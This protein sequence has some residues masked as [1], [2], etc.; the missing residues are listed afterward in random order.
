MTVGLVLNNRDYGVALADSMVTIGDYRKG[1][2]A[3]K[4][5]HINANRFYGAMVGAGDALNI[6]A[7]FEDTKEREFTTPKKMLES[8][9]NFALEYHLNID[10][11]AIESQIKIEEIAKKYKGKMP[12]VDEEQ[13][14]ETESEEEDMFGFRKRKKSILGGLEDY[15]TSDFVAAIYDKREKRIRKYAV[16]A[17]FVA[18]DPFFESVIGSGSDS[19]GLELMRLMSG[20]PL[21]KL[22]K[23]E[24]AFFG[25]CAYVRATQN[26]GVGGIP[27]IALIDKDGSTIVS[28]EDS[29]ALA[30]IVSAYHADLIPRPYAEHN[31]ELVLR[32][33]GKY[34]EVAQSIGMNEFVL[35]NHLVPLDS[36]LNL[37]NNLRYSPK[38]PCKCDGN[39]KEK[40]GDKGCEGDCKKGGCDGKCGKKK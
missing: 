8:V 11:Q 28:R 14:G 18:E 30:N 23:C 17:A 24:I 3:N 34:E 7:T 21:N 9:K 25:L 39:C 27:K 15:M 1:D 26:V 16:N 5:L 2:T 4:L 22:H 20:A 10:R 12:E 40:E 37:G 32:G 36:W 6:F 29:I 33:Q 19:A 38:E 13:E 31:A 35:K